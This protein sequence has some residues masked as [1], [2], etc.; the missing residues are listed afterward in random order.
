MFQPN[1]YC[2]ETCYKGTTLCHQ[3]FVKKSN[4]Y[5]FVSDENVPFNRHSDKV[6]SIELNQLVFCLYL[7]C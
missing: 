5:L 2:K 6:K 3:Y 1:L 7:P 4:V